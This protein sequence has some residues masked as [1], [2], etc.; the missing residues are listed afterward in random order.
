MNKP[1]ALIAALLAALLFAAPASAA[2]KVF[3]LGGQSNMAGLGG[4]SGYLPP[5]WYPWTMPPYD[6]ADAPCPAPYNQPLTSVKFW[7]YTPDNISSSVHNPGVGTGWISL[8]NGYGYRTDQFGPE[9][10]FGA[11]L[12]EMYPNDEINLVKLGVSGA[13]LAGDWNPASG[14]SHNLFT[15]RVTAA[16]NNLA[17]QG[18]TPQIEGMIWMQGE[19][20]AAD[21]TQAANYAQNL[22]NFVASVRDRFDA[23]NM[24]FVVGRITYM[25]E[26]AL[27]ATRSDIDLVRNAQVDVS[28]YV[29]NSSWIDTDDLPW[30]YYGHYGTQGQIDLG[31]RFANQFAVPEPSTLAMIGAGL[32]CFLGYIWRQRK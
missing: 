16:L 15:S 30:A 13:S 5:N 32:V 7:N 19:T 1:L 22:D 24:K 2:T 31:I 14:P 11:K 9:L 26:A 23:D 25:S 18:K 29:S 21:H 17:A 10:S 3:L 20:D 28:T 4:Y 12:R 27:G 8:Q 6:H